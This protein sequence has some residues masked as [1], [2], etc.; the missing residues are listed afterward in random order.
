MRDM[1]HLIPKDYAAISSGKYI[2]VNGEWPFP[3]SNLLTWHP[4][5]LQNFM[6]KLP[7]ASLSD[8]SNLFQSFRQHNLFNFW[9]DSENIKYKKD[10]LF[11]E[12]SF[13]AIDLT[14]IPLLIPKRHNGGTLTSQPLRSTN[15]RTN[16]SDL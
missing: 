8:N 3:S 5:R 7:T 12:L 1:Q 14:K 4:I 16:Q 2:L 10:Y 6:I 13:R 15:K 9:K 11:S